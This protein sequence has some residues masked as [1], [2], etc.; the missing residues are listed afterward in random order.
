MQ[1]RLRRARVAKRANLGRA[2][3][4]VAARAPASLDLRADAGDRGSWLAGVDC[5]AHVGIA[6]VDPQLTALLEHP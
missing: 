2:G 6:Q 5:R 3:V 4:I 1:A